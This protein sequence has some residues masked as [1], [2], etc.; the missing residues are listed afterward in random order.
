VV[1]ADER[2]QTGP[3]V[4]P[5]IILAELDRLVL[6]VVSVGEI[7]SHG[8]SAVEMHELVGTKDE[9]VILR[10]KKVEDETHK[11]MD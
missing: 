9:N 11:P 2:L 8:R 7:R 6:P 3:D 4:P 10:T 1:S 5:A